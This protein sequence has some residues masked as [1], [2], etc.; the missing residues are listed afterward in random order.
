[1]K[2]NTSK[3]TI[4][5]VVKEQEGKGFTTEQYEKLMKGF[6]PLKV[7]G[8]EWEKRGDSYVQ[9]SAYDESMTCIST[10]SLNLIP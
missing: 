9:Y 8:R 5:P 1:M 6:E 10:A 7:I 4:D 3:S 2:T